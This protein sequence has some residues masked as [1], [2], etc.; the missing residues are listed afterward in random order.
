VLSLTLQPK[1]DKKKNVAVVGRALMKSR[2]ASGSALNP[3]GSI[4]HTTELLD[5]AAAAWQTNYSSITQESDLDAFLSTAQLA[6]TE[7]TAERLNVQVIEEVP[8]DLSNMFLLTP[9]AEAE[10]QETHASHRDKLS[11]PRRP[12]WTTQTTK[13][14]LDMLERH[15]FLEWRRGLVILEETLELLMTP[16]ERNL[17][18]WRQLWRVV[19][20]SDMVVQIVDARNPLLFMSGDVTRYVTEVDPRKKNL[21]LIN[22]ADMLGFKQRYERS[23]LMQ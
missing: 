22:K 17:Q 23:N 4:R 19:E 18:V 9:E 21:V 16:Y 15:S 7:F 5:G 3:D 10:L 11:V 1:K 12:D 14:E 13:S 6:G 8:H 20:R 2:F